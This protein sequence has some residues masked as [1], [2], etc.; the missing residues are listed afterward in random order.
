MNVLLTGSSGFIGSYLVETLREAGHRVV[1]V[2]RSSQTWSRPDEFIHGDLLEEGVLE[3]A[4]EGVEAVFHL[5]AAKDDWGISRE[6]YFRDNVEATERLLERGAERGVHTWFFY[7][8]VGVLGEGG[9]PTPE[10][11]AYDPTTD[12][13]ASKVEAEKL[14]RTFVRR[15]PR[16]NVMILRPSAVY[17]PRNPPTTNVHRLIEAIMANRFVMVGNGATPKT[18]SYIENLLAATRFLMDHFEPGVQVYHY[19]DRPVMTTEDLVD[20]IYRAL[21]KDRPSWRLPRSVSRALGSALDVVAA[22][23]GL[24]LPI[25]G[26]RIEKF[27]TP[28]NFDASAVREL[29]FQQEVPNDVAVHRTVR[30]HTGEREA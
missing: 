8:T 18:T 12:Y 28:T 10:D 7:S 22:L 29:G 5:A 26:S 20:T 11:A 9:E 1:G 27:C 30:W 6:E 3:R 14:F 13:G 16:A 17:G 2:D 15:E 21:S 24:D 4:L 23:S 25:T 19:V